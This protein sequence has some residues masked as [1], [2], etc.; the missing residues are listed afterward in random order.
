VV[1]VEGEGVVVAGAASAVESGLRHG[2]HELRRIAWY[3][4]LLLAVIR[5]TDSLVVL[6][7]YHPQGRHDFD[8][9]CTARR[10]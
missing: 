5:D 3:D 10:P 4:D 2:L 7:R 8:R 9:A 6:A 1:E